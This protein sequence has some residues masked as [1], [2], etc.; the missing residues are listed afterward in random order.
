MLVNGL[1]KFHID[2][3]VLGHLQR[4]DTFRTVKISASVRLR[5]PADAKMII[6]SFTLGVTLAGRYIFGTSQ[7][8]FRKF[9]KEVVESN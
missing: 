6:R 3:Q 5:R 2:N 1:L 9:R 7:F 8:S 4:T